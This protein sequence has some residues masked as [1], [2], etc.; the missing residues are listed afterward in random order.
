[1]IRGNDKRGFDNC[2][3]RLIELEY[4]VVR[5]CIKRIKKYYL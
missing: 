2:L 1:M 5:Y 4:W 3:A